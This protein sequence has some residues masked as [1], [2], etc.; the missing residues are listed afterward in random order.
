ML[1]PELQS[2]PVEAVGTSKTV[3]DVEKMDKPQHQQVQ[4]PLQPPVQQAPEQKAAVQTVEQSGGQSVNH[5]SGQIK[6]D[7]KPRPAPEAQPG[8]M[9]KPELQSVPVE[10]V[11]TSKTVAD[12]E[13]MDKP[14][15]QQV[16]Q[17]LQPPV[18]QAP[19]QK[20][21]VQTVEQSGGQSVNHGQAMQWLQPSKKQENDV[22]QLAKATVTSPVAA[23]PKQPGTAQVER[24]RTTRNFPPKGELR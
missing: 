12:V 2:V 23:E 5:G 17:P 19:E 16:Q 20:A 11:G 14:Q 21:A 15:H 3:A 8:Q 18:Q 7:T 13:K 6:E 9:L 1:K 24:Q 10:A 4:Q 22:Q